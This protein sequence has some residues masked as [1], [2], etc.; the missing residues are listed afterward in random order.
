MGPDLKRV[1]EKSGRR[2]QRNGMNHVSTTYMYF[3]YLCAIFFECKQ[4]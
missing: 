2:Q 4:F 1:S 3:Q